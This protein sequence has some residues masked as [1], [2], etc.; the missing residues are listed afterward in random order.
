[1]KKFM[2]ITGAGVAIFVAGVLLVTFSGFFE[3]API[4]PFG[5]FAFMVAAILTIL[6]SAGLF[7]LAFF[8]ARSGRDDISPPN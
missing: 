5:W 8:S 7:A 4:S 2:I 1:M 3:T 6:M